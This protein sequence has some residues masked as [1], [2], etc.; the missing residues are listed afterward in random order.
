MDEREQVVSHLDRA[1]VLAAIRWAHRSA[2]GE[3]WRDFNP[4]GG[5]DQGWVGITAHKLLI[6]R[7]DRVFQAER[8][9][10]QIG[11]AHV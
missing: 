7:Q 8:F 2:Y 5:H 11:R 3:V 6:D 1:G 4:Q 10:V 9:A